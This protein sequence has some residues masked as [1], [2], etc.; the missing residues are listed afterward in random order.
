M[1]KRVLACLIILTFLVIQA[2]P[3]LADSY[4]VTAKVPAPLPVDLPIVTTPGNNSEQQSQTVTI[5]GTCPVIVPALIVV[6]ERN[7]QTIGSGSCASNGVFRIIVGLVLGVNVIYPKFMTITGESGGFGSALTMTYAQTETAQNT[8]TQTAE[9]LLTAR[10]A[11][12]QATG[13]LKLIF[14]YDFVTYNT[15][16]KTNLTAG[17]SG[18][19]K[20]FVL[21]IEWGDGSSKKYNLNDDKVPEL[22][23]QYKSVSAEPMKL[24]I[25]LTDADNNKVQTERALVSFEKPN[26]V[27][28]AAA[29]P[30]KVGGISMTAAVVWIVATAGALILIVTQYSGVVAQFS[31][32]SVKT[33]LKSKSIS[34]A[35]GKK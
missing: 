8:P 3:T 6:L 9:P 33:G 7:A 19:K 34:R 10:P 15:I 29:Q 22:S 24:R 27:A 31:H 14:D 2:V 35:R 25:T 5:I 30:I 13:T 20:P 17:I 16:Q 11:N 21:T 4:E 18:G 32:N 1:H 28:P 26:Q 23:H 12:N